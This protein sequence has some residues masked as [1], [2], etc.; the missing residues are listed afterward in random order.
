MKLL[1]IRH[2]D[3]DYAK[4]SL[5]EKGWKEAEYLSQMLC[6]QD[7]TSFYVSPYGRARD[8]ASLT[9]EKMH[10]TA[11]VLPWLKEFDTRVFR[12]D[13]PVKKHIMW[14]WLP[15]DWTQDPRLYQKDQWSERDCFAENG[16]GEEYRQVTEQFDALLEKHGYKREGGYYRA[17]RPNH[18]TIAL[19]CHFGSMAVLLSHLWGVSPMIIWQN[20][21]AAPSSVTTLVTEERRRGIASF[22]TLA[23]GET[24]HLYVCGEPPAFAARFCECFDDETRHDDY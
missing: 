3:P 16:I 18:D 22:R 17:E 1:L 11:E 7:I 13:D 10:R 5:T 14:D 2:G 12:P 4:D 15:Q 20:C 23:Y 6:K 21:C 8:T 24:S 9:L 19:F